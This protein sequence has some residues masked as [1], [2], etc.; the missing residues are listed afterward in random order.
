MHRFIAPLAVVAAV[1][2]NPAAAQ[3][4]IA[5]SGPTGEMTITESI[6]AEP[7]IASV[8]AGVTTEAET[9]VEAMRLNA[10][11]MSA[12]IEQIRALD[13]PERDIQTTGINLGARYDYDQ[14][15]R[16]QVFR[17]YQAS[18][19]VSVTM[20]DIP[21]IGELLD[22]LVGAAHILHARSPGSPALR[23]K[24]LQHGDLAAL[25]DQLPN[26]VCIATGWDQYFHTALRAQHPY[27]ELELVHALWRRGA[28]VLGVDTLS[29]DPTSG[30]AASFAVHEFW[31]GSGGVIVENLRGLTGL[32]DRVQM[33]LLP[34]NLRGLD[35]SP[36]RAV[37]W[38]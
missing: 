21:R 7:D 12:V 36:I 5:A 9:A 35:G 38:D 22:L 17:G 8:S 3:V 37:A 18:N 25:P 26:I 1:A 19:R 23:D 27:L 29:P 16:R 6:E 31:L 34:L 15:T 11:A 33:S 30:A 20:R 14:A 24:G 4:Q 13:I 32:S 28:R 2:A 10:Q